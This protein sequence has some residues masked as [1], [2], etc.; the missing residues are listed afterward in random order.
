L[1]GDA[2][3]VLETLGDGEEPVP[4]EP[5]SVDP[6]A[7]VTKTRAVSATNLLNLEFPDH[8]CPPAL[9]LKVTSRWAP[10]FS[11]IAESEPSRGKGATGGIGLRSFVQTCRAAGQP[12][13]PERRQKR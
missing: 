2:A 11:L 9:P 3:G 1:V 13:R 5:V 6:Q 8:F 4:E 10:F 7:A 12:G